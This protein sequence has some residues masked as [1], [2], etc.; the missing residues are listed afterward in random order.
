MDEAAHTREV[1]LTV[2]RRGLEFPER[3]LLVGLPVERGPLDLPAGV[4]EL[5]E[6][7]VDRLGLIFPRVSGSSSKRK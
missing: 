2:A 3:R 4:G 7:E 1:E 5:F 6:E